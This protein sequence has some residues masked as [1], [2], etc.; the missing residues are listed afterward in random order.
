MILNLAFW[1]GL[2]MLFAQEREVAA[3]SLALD[4]P[5]LAS[6]NLLSLLLAAAAG[7]V[8]YPTG[9]VQPWL[10]PATGRPRRRPRRTRGDP[11]GRLE[12]RRDLPAPMATTVCRVMPIRLAKSLTVLVRA[13]LP[14][15]SAIRR[16]RD[17][18]GKQAL[19]FRSRRRPFRAMADAG[20]A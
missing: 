8:L 15:R 20:R 7:V 16:H 14:T 5:V 13:V 19:T 9:I 12:R 4:L 6:V 18:R 1:F 2:R 11:E 17:Q 10:T 3:C